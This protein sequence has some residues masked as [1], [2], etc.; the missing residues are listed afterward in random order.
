M[1][2]FARHLPKSDRISQQAARTQLTQLL[3][4]CTDAALAGFTAE[5]LAATHRVPLKECE[6]ALTI[7]RQR[8]GL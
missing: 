4:G 8:R 6:Y 2:R 7:A 5:H 1:S 3:V